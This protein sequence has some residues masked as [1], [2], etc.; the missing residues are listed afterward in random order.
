MTKEIGLITKEEK[1][2][3]KIEYDM[4]IL[5]Q[6]LIERVPEHFS[7]R[8]VINALFGSFIL[9]STFVFNGALVKTV[10]LQ[11]PARVFAIVLVTFA[12]LIAEIYF[13]SYSR[14]KHKERRHFGQFLT[15]RL[16]S[17]YFVSLFVSFILVY[18]AGVNLLAGSIYESLKIVINIAM[19][20]AVG[21]AIPSLLKKY[22]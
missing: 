6:K 18:L 1:E 22:V 2:I 10:S 5:R 9:G 12:I 8:D 15:K 13:V 3:R 7:K 14:V 20:C 4:E 21:A 11:S 19:P 17:L 16:V